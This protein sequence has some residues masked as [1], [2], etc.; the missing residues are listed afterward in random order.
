MPKSNVVL[1][2]VDRFNDQGM[3]SESVVWLKAAM[4]E[5]QPDDQGMAAIGRINQKIND[6]SGWTG[7]H[8][9]CGILCWGE[10]ALILFSCHPV[11]LRSVNA[12]SIG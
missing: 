5:M 8:P 7:Y 6:T 1:H 4:G 11:V 10:L 2:G 12:V 9:F 3:L